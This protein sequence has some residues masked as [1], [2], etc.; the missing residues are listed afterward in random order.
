LGGSGWSATFIKGK[1]E[2]T[3]VFRCKEKGKRAE[4]ATRDKPAKKLPEG[5]R[6]QGKKNDLGIGRG[7]K[8]GNVPASGLKWTKGTFY[9]GRSKQRQRKKRRKRGM[10]GVQD[11]P[12]V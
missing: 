5:S 7:E 2:G 9:G 12:A 6:E 11:T 4:K 8:K 3:G 10:Y 1:F